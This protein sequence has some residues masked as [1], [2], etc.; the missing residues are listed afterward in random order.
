MQT[1]GTISIPMYNCELTV[2]FTDGSLNKVY[3][4]L[5]KKHDEYHPV[6]EEPGGIAFSPDNDI[7][8]YYIIL[9]CINST[10]EI[11]PFVHEIDHIKN[12]ILQHRN[13]HYTRSNDESGAYL[14]GYIGDCIYKLM[15]KK[16][17][18]F[19]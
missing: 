16:Q 13:V 7:T 11:W 14:A 8:I 2:I 19:K 1:R 18:V 4:S 9:S 17:I 12:Y 3:K 15:N 10:V 6:A 5:M